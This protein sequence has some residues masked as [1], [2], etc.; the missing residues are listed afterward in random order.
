MDDSDAVDVSIYGHRLTVSRSDYLKGKI[1]V[2]GVPRPAPREGAAPASADPEPQAR[3]VARVQ[4]HHR[5]AAGPTRPA[6][7]IDLSFVPDD[8][9]PVDFHVPDIDH[10]EKYISME[11]KPHVLDA[12]TFDY[13]G[14]RYR[15]YGVDAPEEAQTV[16]I[17]GKTVSGAE[18]TKRLAQFLAGKN[19]TVEDT[20]K[21][22]RGQKGRNRVV[23]RLYADGRDVAAWEVEQGLAQPIPRFSGD[24][25]LLAL[26]KARAHGM[27]DFEQPHDY[28]RAHPK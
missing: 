10:P 4:K 27:G 3:P 6:N 1:R 18:V 2:L 13:G 16:S 9:I 17:Q 7:G 19:L 26:K 15:L 20:G 14:T 12:D 23:G 8:Y 28:R 5:S 25:Y 11:D 21:K 22:A 24:E